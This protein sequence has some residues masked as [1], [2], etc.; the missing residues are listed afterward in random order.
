M[1]AS[2]GVNANPQRVFRA[3][4]FVS[5]FIFVV[6][7]AALVGLN[8]SQYKQILSYE[9]SLLLR[10]N[11]P[12]LV[13]RRFRELTEQAG[14]AEQKWKL[15]IQNTVDKNQF[16]SSSPDLPAL[17]VC[18]SE[19][20]LQYDVTLC[21]PQV[22]PWNY[23]GLITS[24]YIAIL[25]LTSV[26]LSRAHNKLIRAFKEFFDAA[27]LNAPAPLTFQSAWSYASDMASNFRE[28]QLK[29]A[30][31]GRAEA[32]SS[33]A[34]QVAH[35]I[36]SP[37]SALNIVAASLTDVSEEKRQMIKTAAARINKIADSLLSKRVPS[38]SSDRPI[39]DI[40][41]TVA[42]ILDEKRIE[43]EQY[44]NITFSFEHASGDICAQIDETDF[45]RCLSNIINNS[46][47]AVDKEGGKIHVSA[48]EHGSLVKIVVHDNGPGIAPEVLPRIGQVGATFGK[49][50]RGS[51][52]GLGLFQA[53]SVV[54]KWKGNINFHSQLGAGTSVEIT[55]PKLD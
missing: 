49:Q 38:E 16:V 2:V 20:Y 11:G 44:P 36:R 37:V 52:F 26:A 8:Q 10:S 6:S 5:A 30:E 24:L 32:L 25:I 1:A 7:I 27:S 3:V 15:Q 46:V 19:S 18:V 9:L 55:L 29:S 42:L 14:F 33:I 53:K 28:L 48:S 23:L 13:E 17:L 21:R 51:G 31:F 39:T 45:A 47:D 40:T 12:L 43:H 50:K 35:D 34:S 22:I 54:E 4:L 41:K